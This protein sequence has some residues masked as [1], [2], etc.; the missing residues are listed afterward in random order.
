MLN[1]WSNTSNVQSAC[2][3]FDTP[4]KTMSLLI[5]RLMNCPLLHSWPCFS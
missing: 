1:L 4:S 5:N 3:G 2:F